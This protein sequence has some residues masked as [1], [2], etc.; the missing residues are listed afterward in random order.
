MS[1]II[2]IYK[3]EKF[4]YKRLI[5]KLLKEF[6]LWLSEWFANLTRTHEDTGSIPG[7]PQW[8]KDLVLP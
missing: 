6:L 2:S 1:I 4:N 8:V 5:K 3:S 7:P